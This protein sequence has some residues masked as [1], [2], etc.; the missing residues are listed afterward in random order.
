MNRTNTAK[1]MEKY[2]R[3]QINVQKDGKRRSFTS[4]T[5]GRAGR[6]EANAKA[7]AWLDDG[8]DSK[9]LRIDD[10]CDEY[11]ADLKLR[12]SK[13]HWRPEESRVNIWIKPNIG[14]F[15][16]D[17]ITDQ[18][19][20]S[21]INTAYSKGLSKKTLMNLRAT[22]V[23]F[24][25]YCRKRKACNF[26]PE[27]L[28]LPNSATSKEKSILHP[29]DIVKLFT[30]DTTVYRNKRI[31][32]PLIN[33]YR[34]AVV[35]GYRPGEILGFMP[36]D[37]DG[38]SLKVNRSINIYGEIT[39]GKNQNARRVRVLSPLAKSIWEDQMK[40]SDGIYVFGN[41]PEQTMLEH[42]KRYCHANGLTVTTLYELRHTF[43]SAIQSLP[44]SYIK[45]L[46]G[47]ANSMDTFGTYIHE[48][49]DTQ[50]KIATAVEEIFLE[51]LSCQKAKTK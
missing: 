3:W 29:E 36:N 15:K 38:I 4:S 37:F 25:K 19:C 23:A 51:I 35:T 20:Q 34:F 44:E 31:P 49:D 1:W 33:A 24:F 21:I 5:P 18:M 12:T 42:W 11:I 22:L 45:N 7:D 43:T 40:H 17:K 32:D 27:D 39:Q 6:R 16:P 10:L 13:S 14:R 2:G 50:Q 47:H 28:S 41:V 9:K 8:I 30:E 46:V 26:M 48:M